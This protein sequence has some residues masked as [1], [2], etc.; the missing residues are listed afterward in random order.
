M[1]TALAEPEDTAPCWACGRKG[2]AKTNRM[3]A[4][5]GTQR[6]CEDTQ[7]CRAAVLERI[8]DVLTRYRREST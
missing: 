7:A 6:C 3:I 1:K 2:T 4:G 5:Y 8:Q